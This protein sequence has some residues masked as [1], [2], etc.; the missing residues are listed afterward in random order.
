[1]SECLRH[2]HPPCHR[3]RRSLEVWSRSPPGSRGFWDLRSAAERSI[4][5][6]PLCCRLRHTFFAG[7]FLAVSGSFFGSE[8]NS[9]GRSRLQGFRDR[10]ISLRKL[11]PDAFLSPQCIWKKIWAPFPLPERAKVSGRFRSTLLAP[12]Q[13]DMPLRI[14]S[15]I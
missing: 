1:V 7:V 11:V 5:C 2:G 6:R 4:R 14:A 3:P 15:I 9:S 10:L 13:T 12:D 8:H